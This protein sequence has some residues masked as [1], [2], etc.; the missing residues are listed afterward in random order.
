MS[1]SSVLLIAE[2][3]I[4]SLTGGT[5]RPSAWCYVGQKLQIPASLFDLWQLTLCSFIPHLFS[6]IAVA[7]VYLAA[8]TR[9]EL[10]KWKKLF[11]GVLT[12]GVAI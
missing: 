12:L 4:L 3:V 7:A 1:N 11:H 6:L 2:A 10:E 5:R 9:A 8:V